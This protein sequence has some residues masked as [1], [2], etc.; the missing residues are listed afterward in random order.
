VKEMPGIP[1]EQKHFENSYSLIIIRRTEDIEGVRSIWEKM[2]SRPNADIDHYLAVVRARADH[3]RPHVIILIQSGEPIALLICRVEKKK[4]EVKIGY[5]IVSG[6]EI[7]HL[8]VIYGGMLGDFAQHHAGYFIDEL[9]DTLARR[10][11]DVVLFES[12]SLESSIY[13]EVLSKPRSLCKD[14]FPTI[15]SHWRL[16]IPG[17]YDEYFRHL[18]ARTR[19]RLKNDMNKLLKKYGEVLR[20]RYYDQKDDLEM[21]LKDME[22]ITQKTYKRRLGFGFVDNA[23]TR[24]RYLVA[25]KKGW[26]RVYFLY[27]S[28]IPIAYWSGFHFESKYYGEMTGYDP[29]YRDYSPGIFLL[30]KMIEHLYNEYKVTMID[31]GQGD[32]EY[33]YI[34]C[35]E[36][37]EKASLYIFSPAMKIVLLNVARMIIVSASRVIEFF[38]DR[39]QLKGK[40]KR[41]WRHGIFEKG[42][43]IEQD[44]RE[45]QKSIAKRDHSIVERLREERPKK[46]TQ[47]EYSPTSFE[48]VKLKRDIESGVPAFELFYEANLCK[49]KSEARR[50]ISQGGAYVNDRRIA[51]FD[52]K[53]SLQDFGNQEILYL[54][55]GKKLKA[56]V[57]LM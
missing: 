20:I 23:L 24:Q 10:E 22:Y 26:L 33:K 5:K 29:E 16:T 3:C 6:P 55:R 46:Q 7:N 19:A 54:R 40:L 56:I 1:A 47:R 13:K 48:I 14:Y 49:S 37:C 32:S 44:R 8:I 28:D 39:F 27:F 21:I 42:S 51:E 34:Y 36:R 50:I 53:I 4:F 17:T 15:H 45:I 12:V 18:S 52:E 57:K 30:M 2:I 35:N 41:I 38:L 11:V 43:L 25:S 9:L 31:F